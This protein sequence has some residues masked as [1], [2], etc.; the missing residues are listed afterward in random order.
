MWQGK[1][2]P[3]RLQRK[4]RL[5]RRWQMAHIGMVGQGGQGPEQVGVRGSHYDRGIGEAWRVAKE[6]DSHIE[7]KTNTGQSLVTS[8]E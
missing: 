7:N 1:G 2:Q 8:N 3:R 6:W 5:I 4:E